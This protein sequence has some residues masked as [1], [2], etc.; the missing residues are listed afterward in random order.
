MRFLRYTQL[1][2][3]TRIMYNVCCHTTGVRQQDH[4]AMETAGSINYLAYTP[5]S[6]NIIYS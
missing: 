6:I 5:Y 1:L 3:I 2:E 4:V